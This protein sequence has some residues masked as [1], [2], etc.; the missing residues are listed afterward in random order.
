MRILYIGDASPRSTSLQRANAL[1][2]MGHDVTVLA[3]KEALPEHRIISSW[4]VRTGFRFTSAVYADYILKSAQQCEVDLVW[5][6]HGAEC[7]AQVVK[8]LKRRFGRIIN[9]NTDDPF[10]SRDLNKWRL[11][12]D[13][14]PHYDLTVVVRP[15]NV[16]E[17]R[18]LGASEVMR[19]WMTADEVA[20][21]PRVL[22][23][24]DVER[25]QSQVLFIGDWMPERG[26]FMAELIRRGVPLTLCGARWDKAPEWSTLAPH[27]RPSVFGDAYA[28]HIQSAA[29]CLGLLS[30]GNR[31]QHTTRSAEIPYLGGLLLAERTE[32]HLAMY[33]ENEE[34]VFWD[35]PESCA[36][37]CFELLAAPDRRRTIANAGRRRALNSGYTNEVVLGRIL[38]QVQ[39]LPHG[40]ESA[41]SRS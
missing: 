7:S 24:E 15:I 3:I 36:A 20:H 11:Y 32:E 13:A 12:R 9:Y 37:R 21:A 1:K 35:D 31:D 34:A 27:W 17:A 16:S 28:M 19:V 33:R 4:N 38:A 26:P 29:V 18:A 14:L 5:I 10:G 25:Y 22:G 2:R 39:Q 23:P 8:E 6:N 40:G 30:K 41:G